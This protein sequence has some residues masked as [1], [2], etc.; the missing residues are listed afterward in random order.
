[1]GPVDVGG[2]SGEIHPASTVV[3][4]IEIL[5]KYKPDLKVLYGASES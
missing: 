1:M 3:N 5:S 2:G 4:I